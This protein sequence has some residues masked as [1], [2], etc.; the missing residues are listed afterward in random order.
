MLRAYV[1][2]ANKNGL[3]ALWPEQEHTREAAFARAYRRPPEPAVCFWAVLS[4]QVAESAQLLLESAQ[5]LGA[6]RTVD[7][8]S[9]SIGPIL[10]S[11]NRLD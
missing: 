5:S 9:L 6:L 3:E 7:T 8:C 10:P 11:T 1:G 2:V 4:D